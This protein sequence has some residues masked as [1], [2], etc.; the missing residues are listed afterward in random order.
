MRYRT[1]VLEEKLRFVME[2]ERDVQSMTKL[3]GS[4]GVSRETEYVWL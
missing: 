3:C 4:F 2:Y 1:S